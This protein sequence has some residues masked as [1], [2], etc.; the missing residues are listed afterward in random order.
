MSVPTSVSF[1]FAS[2]LVYQGSPLGG[3][4]SFAVRTSSSKRSFGTA[5][6]PRMTVLKCWN[7]GFETRARVDVLTL[8]QRVGFTD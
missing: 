8:S 2:S 3:D 1:A 4:S 6:T 7:S 5:S